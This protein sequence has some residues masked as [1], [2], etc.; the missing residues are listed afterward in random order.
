[1]LSLL[2]GAGVEHGPLLSD[3]RSA[4]NE[5]QQN[6]SCDLWDG[7]EGRRRMRK[8]SSGSSGLTE[9]KSFGELVSRSSTLGS[10]QWRSYPLDREAPFGSLAPQDGSRARHDSDRGSTLRSAEPPIAINERS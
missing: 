2:G 9:R 10:A 3:A 1:M 4:Q 5:Q 6:A 8:A 7:F